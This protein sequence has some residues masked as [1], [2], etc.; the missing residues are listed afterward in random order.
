MLICLAAECT[1]TYSLSKYEDL[2]D[3][4][5]DRFAPA[6]LYNNDMSAA[7]SLHPLSLGTCS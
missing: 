7:P 4:V 3:H 5:E 1:A 2:Q 6:H